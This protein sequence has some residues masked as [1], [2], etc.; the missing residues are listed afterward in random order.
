MK[1]YITASRVIKEQAAKKL[2]LLILSCFYFYRCSPPPIDYIYINSGFEYE[3]EKE[4]LESILNSEDLS[5]HNLQLLSGSQQASIHI[6]F[7]TAWEYETSAG[8][9]IISRKFLIPHDDFLAGR[10]NTS[11]AACLDGSEKL[12]Q[13]DE[14]MP[15]FTALK[16]DSLAAGDKDYPLVQVTGIRLRIDEKIE[17]ENRLLD[18]INIIINT[19]K[20]APKPLCQ[21]VP[22]LIWITAGGDTMLERGASEIL[23]NEGPSGIFGKTAE[24]LASSDIAL[25][26]L[27]GV[28]SSRG[29]RVSKSFTFRFVPEIAQALTNA[30]I[31]AVLH[32]NNHVF[33]YGEEAFLDSLYN[34]NQAGIGIAGAGIDDEA[35]SNP[36]VFKKDGYEVRV[37]GIASFPRENN[38]WDGVNAAAGPG[39]AGMLHAQRGGIDKIKQKL[40]PG[41]LNVILFH[42]GIEWSAEPDEATRKMYT[43]LIASGADLVIGTH[44]HI[45]QGFEWVLGKPVF[46]SLGNYVFGRMNGFYTGDEGLFIRLGY[47]NGKLLYIEP[48][49]I[50]LNNMRTDIVSQDKLKT[51]YDRSKKLR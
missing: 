5:A 43:D 48:F 8:D 51:F 1:N 20:A 40:L 46:W 7:F 13:I 41:T 24:M 47:R 49:P 42:G 3:A 26:N 18:K 14:L 15:P 9:I 28:I 12:I 37:F 22:E 39:R 4:F 34:L 45:V 16:V 50:F 6:E 38:G 19:V 17:S 32:A 29:Q 36:V 35:A 10:T 44:P 11:L 25:L 30:G 21:P 31:N 33:D 23:L 27:E 2:I